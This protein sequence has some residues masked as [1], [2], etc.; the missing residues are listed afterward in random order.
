MAHARNEQAFA[1]RH[2]R[3]MRYHKDVCAGR[4]PWNP[5]VG[6]FLS[7]IGSSKGEFKMH[8]SRAA[9]IGTIALALCSAG[10]FAQELRLGTISRVDEA[11]GTIAIAE[12]Q[13]GTTGSS[14]GAA[15]QEFKLQDG[16]LFNAIKEGD[17]ISYA[18]EDIRGV[19]TITKLQKQ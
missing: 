10:V 2:S 11:N 17:R 16:L 4:S 3:R 9:V 1:H 5:P 18:V 19:K 13:I 7:K 14:A 8:T 15:A 12:T 6:C